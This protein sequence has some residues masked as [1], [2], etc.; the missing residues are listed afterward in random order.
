MKILSTDKLLLWLVL[1]F[2]WLFPN[3][4]LAQTNLQE[5]NCKGTDYI[6]K[7]DRTVG[8]LTNVNLLRCENNVLFAELTTG[9]FKLRKNNSWI[10]IKQL[11]T[12]GANSY[13]LLKSDGSVYNAKGHTKLGNLASTD[14]L[15]SNDKQLVAISGNTY[16]KFDG[17]NWN[18][19]TP[20]FVPDNLTMTD[21]GLWFFIQNRAAYD[22]K[23]DIF[24]RDGLTLN[25]SN[26]PVMETIPLRG[27]FDKFLWR[28]N[29][30]SGSTFELI[31]KAGSK[32]LN[33]GN[34]SQFTLSLANKTIFGT[35]AY[36][37]KQGTKS[38]TYN[39]RSPQLVDNN[40]SN[41]QVWL[42]HFNQMVSGYMLPRNAGTDP[43]LRTNYYDRV[44][45]GQ[46]NTTFLASKTSSDWALASSYF[47]QT[48]IINA[49]KDQAWIMGDPANPNAGKGITRYFCY[50]INK[51]DPDNTIPSNGNFTNVPNINL[52]AHR[53]GAN[54]GDN[55]LVTSEE[56]MGRVGPTHFTNDQK[57]SEFDHPVHEFFHILEGRLGPVSQTF[58][59]AKKDAP[60]VKDLQATGL[61]PDYLDGTQN[62]DTE[63][64]A[65]IGEYYFNSFLGKHTY[66]GNRLASNWDETKLLSF[67]H[68]YF[69]P[70]NIWFPPT[71]LRAEFEGDL[72]RE[73]NTNPIEITSSS[74]YLKEGFV[75][76]SA[77][78]KYALKINSDGNMVLHNNIEKRFFWNAY[79]D[80]KSDPSS[81]WPKGFGAGS[82]KVKFENGNLSIHKASDNSLKWESNTSG[83][84]GARI[85]LNHA[86]QL[87]ILDANNNE[88]FP[89]PDPIPTQVMNCNRSRTGAK[90]TLLSHQGNLIKLKVDWD[91]GSTF[92]SGSL[93]LTNGKCIS[94]PRIGGIGRPHGIE[95]TYEIEQIATSKPVR[96]AWG[97]RGTRNYCGNDEIVVGN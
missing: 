58:K 61:F 77:N 49:V 25:A 5:I 69:N 94:C 56:F 66:P 80:H 10:D 83:Y 45:K 51:N 3:N 4:L 26:Q 75:L 82:F 19:F 84:T 76:H 13:Y 27:K 74:T 33:F 91:E 22:I 57:Y 68:K 93:A 47:V 71:T 79:E 59:A 65:I 73:N 78:E 62:E 38:L 44:L 90:I 60:F 64:L 20:N 87:M 72:T 14:Y 1:M 52:D 95:A 50:V 96:I 29:R 6:L 37:I 32:K 34:S 11:I 23:G 31:N 41:E 24:R 43:A 86:H 63:I 40:N 15:I 16:R 70:A 85:V 42:L 48:N 9:D 55:W 39:Q 46:Y 21:E 12:I 53:G 28:V 30:I 97:I 2:S 18:T 89:N 7:A 92:S 8:S 17:T 36:K 88:I 35:T 81:K 54:S 67:L